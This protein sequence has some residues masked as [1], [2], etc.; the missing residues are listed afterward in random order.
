MDELNNFN[1]S[2]STN[3]DSWSD[4]GSSG[5]YSIVLYIVTALMAAAGAYVAWRYVSG[6]RDFGFDI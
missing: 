6:G 1:D 2:V 3:D 4:S 5:S